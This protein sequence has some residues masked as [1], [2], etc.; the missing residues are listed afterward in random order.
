MFY[1]WTGEKKTRQ[2]RLIAMTEGVV[3]DCCSRI[4]RTVDSPLPRV[5]DVGESGADSSRSRSGERN[6]WRC[7]RHLEPQMRHVEGYDM[8]GQS[9][10]IAPSGEIVAMCHTFADELVAH[11]CDLDAGRYSRDTVSNFA[12]HRRTET[13]GLIVGRTGVGPRIAP[14]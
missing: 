14:L 8:I 2:P 3:R 7:I 9:A 11:G 4:R 12:A 13:C 10:I 6:L 1:E 5:A